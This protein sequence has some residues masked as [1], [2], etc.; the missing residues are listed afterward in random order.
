M[1]TLVEWLELRTD[2]TCESCQRAIA[3]LKNLDKFPIEQKLKFVLIP[4]RLENHATRW[5]IG[6]NG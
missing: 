3:D 5:H 2:P 1:E 4:D 6:R